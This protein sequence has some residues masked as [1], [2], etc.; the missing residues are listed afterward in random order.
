MKKIK[1][2]IIPAAGLGT[3]FLPETK[4]MPKEML[5]VVDKPAIQL[6]VEE[7]IESGITDILII[8]GKGK[9]AIEDHFDSN[10][11]LELNLESKGK[12][13]MLEAVKKTNGLNIYFKRQEHPNGLGDAVYTAKSFVGDDPFVIM[14]GDDLMEDKTPLTKQLID[15]YE[16]TGSSTLAVMR[17]PHEDTSKYGVINPA[18]EVKDGLYDVVNFVEK[19]NPEDAPSDLAIIGRYLLTPEIF[20]ILENTKPGKGNE[21]QLTDAIDTL[22]KDGKVYAHEFK[23]DRFDTGN[24]FG[25]L[26]TNIEFGLQHP[27]VADQLK[28]YIKDLAKKL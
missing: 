15:S 9:R 8:I 4:A 2:A 7:A 14:L 20:D 16:E 13:E 6:I 17:V 1:K 25:W 21:V 3:R 22:N 19:P 26:Q 24:K 12:K 11:E 28:E 10:T 23:G 18:K 27:E 5:P